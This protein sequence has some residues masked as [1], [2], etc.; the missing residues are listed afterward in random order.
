MRKEAVAK[1]AEYMKGRRDEQENRTLEKLTAKKGHV[2]ATP[3]KKRVLQRIGETA[4]WHTTSAAERDKETRPEATAE[5]E[6]AKQKEAE[7]NN[8]KV[9]E[10]EDKYDC[11]PDKEQM[12]QERMREYSARG[13]IEC[14]MDEVEED[15]QE[16]GGRKR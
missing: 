8:T 10:E 14:A 9:E 13:Y 11:N 15:A 1:R 4:T 3:L 12:E 16:K 2:K 5:E 7:A 6:G